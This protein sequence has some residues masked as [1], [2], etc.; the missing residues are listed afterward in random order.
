MMDDS[1]SILGIG[2]GASTKLIGGQRGIERVTECKY[3]DEYLRRYDELMAKKRSLV[4][5]KH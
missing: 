3:P 4:I 1:Q 5:P 2:S